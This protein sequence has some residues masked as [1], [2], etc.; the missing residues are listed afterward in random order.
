LSRRTGAI[1]LLATTVPMLWS[2]LLFNFFANFILGIDASFVGWLLGT[3]R[4]GNV[5]DFADNS[6]ALVILR[7]CSSLA[8]MSLAFLCWVTISQSVRHRWS[9]RDAL[10]CLLAC[11]S[12]I[13]VN[14]TRMSLMGLSQWHYQAVHN[15]WGDTVSNLIIVGLTIGIS[16][17][18]VRHELFS[19]TISPPSAI[20]SL[21]SSASSYGPMWFVALLLAL[22]LLWKVAVAPD[23]PEK[24]TSEIRNFFAHQQFDVAVTSEMSVPMV[25]ATSGSCHI[26]IAN[27]EPNGS[28]ED[29][30]RAHA[31][32]T[33]RVFIVFQGRAYDRQPVLST[34]VNSLWSEFLRKF[35]LVRHITPVFAVVATAYC[36]AEQLPWEVLH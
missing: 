35:G 28:Y 1:I 18:G 6:G 5:V 14:V 20:G 34:M 26:L 4:T 33:D 15:Q 25:Q 31:T 23:D 12:V 8:N 36:D 2:L 32:A 22:T 13:A 7:P 11:M 27:V 3:H 29:F 24:L 19:R 16:L 17:L 9:P 21:T 30:I 10:W